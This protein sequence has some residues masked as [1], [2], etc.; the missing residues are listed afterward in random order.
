MEDW[1]MHFSVKRWKREKFKYVLLNWFEYFDNDNSLSI[2]NINKFAEMFNIDKSELSDTI[3]NIIPEKIEVLSDESIYSAFHLIK[4]RLSK[5]ENESIIEWILSRWNSNIDSSFGDGLW[6]KELAPPPNSKEVLMHFLRFSLGQPDK[7]LRWRAI[8]SIR[9]L[10]MYGETEIL[11]FLLNKQNTV[12]CLPF[13]NRNYIFYWI[14]AKL[15]LWIAIERISSESPE[16]LGVFKDSFLHELKNNDLP[17]VLIKY[18]IKNTCLNLISYEK[19]IYDQKDIKFIK[20]C[21]KS[22]LKKVIEKRLSRKQRKYQSQIHD[23][24]RFHFD[25]LD[26]LP[27]W[28]SR[29]ARV[30]NLSEYDVADLSDKYIV[31]NWGYLGDTSEDDYTSQYEWTLKDKR[32]GSNP[33]VETLDTYFEY[34]AMFCSAHDLL[35]KEPQLESEYNDSWDS[36]E[37]WLESNSN[38]WNKFWLSDLRDSTPLEGKF[39]KIENEKFDEKWRDNIDDEK[40]DLEVINNE[41]NCLIPYAG[42]QRYIGENTESVSIRSALVSEKGSEALMRA[43]QSAKNHHDYAFPMEKSN[44]EFEI[45]NY[46]F[47]FESWLYTENTERE[48]LDSHDYLSKDTGKNIIRIGEKVKKIFPISFSENNKKGYYNGNLISSY[49][50]WNEINDHRNRSSDLLESGGAILKVDIDFV[51]ELLGNTKKNLILECHITRQLKERSYNYDDNK[52]P[53]ETTKLYLIKPDGRIRTIRGGDIKI[54]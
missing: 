31:E 52:T 22:K 18:Y 19:D 8:H 42:Y 44:E 28:Y 10:F 54:R 4:D 39:W 6:N 34:N 5:E 49:L 48:G 29:L 27:Y 36:W 41:A 11:E 14:S 16:K 50:N 15:Y 37:Y 1:T 47:A 30:F 32:H 43:L 24:W 45:D 35:L 13:Q 33:T 26:V 3:V 2:W 7:N 23:N 12:N 51:L 20:D 17:H 25:T 53:W 40:L 38:T 9:R 21:L 46:G